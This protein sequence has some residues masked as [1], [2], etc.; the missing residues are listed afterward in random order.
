MSK[1]IDLLVIPDADFEFSIYC[2]FEDANFHDG[3]FVCEN[4]RLTDNG[5]RMG[6]NVELTDTARLY[7]A[8]SR[9]RCERG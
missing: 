9:E 4:S 5:Y 7:R 3:S 2:W 1:A 6:P 8:A